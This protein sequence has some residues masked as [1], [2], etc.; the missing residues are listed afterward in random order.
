MITKSDFKEVMLALCGIPLAAFLTFAD[1]QVK[2]QKSEVK[3]DFVEHVMQNNWLTNAKAVEISSLNADRCTPNDNRRVL[4]F[5]DVDYGEVAGSA[6]KLHISIVKDDAVKGDDT[7]K[8]L[9]C[10]SLY[11]PK[12]ES[13]TFPLRAEAYAINLG[14]EYW[15]KQN[16]QVLGL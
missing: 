13:P 3:R 6:V 8:A 10:A 14:D 4:F 7:P 16:R 11:H 1:H 9:L 12:V 2:M 15:A 5:D